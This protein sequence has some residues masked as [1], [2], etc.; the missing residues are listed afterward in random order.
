VEGKLQIKLAD[1][2][3]ETKPEKNKIIPTSKSI[4]LK[5]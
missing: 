1:D 4:K 2:P 5:L 3:V